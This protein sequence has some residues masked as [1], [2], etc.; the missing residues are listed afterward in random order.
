MKNLKKIHL[1]NKKYQLLKNIVVLEACV[2]SYNAHSKISFILEFFE[3]F[4]V[5]KWG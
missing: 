3:P 1:I 2:Y 4:Q 5:I